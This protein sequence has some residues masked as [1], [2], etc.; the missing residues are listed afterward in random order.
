MYLP[1]GLQFKD[2]L[3][4]LLANYYTVRPH[5]SRLHCLV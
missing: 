5:L 4:V 2:L 1:V 3:G